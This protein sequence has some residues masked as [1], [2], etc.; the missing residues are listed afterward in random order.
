MNLSNRVRAVLTVALLFSSLFLPEVQGQAGDFFV[1]NYH[2]EEYKGSPQVFMSTEDDDGLVYF[3]SNEGV[4]IFDGSRWQQITLPNRSR[5]NHLASLDPGR[6]FVCATAEFGQLISGKGREIT[7]QSFKHRLPE[8]ERDFQEVIHCYALPDHR[9]FITR[10]RIFCIGDRDQSILAVTPIGGV[11]I[12]NDVFIIQKD[13]PGF[14]SLHP[15]GLR[16]VPKSDGLGT[17]TALAQYN[18]KEILIKTAT[19]LLRFT[20]SR[21]PQPDEP[22]SSAVGGILDRLKDPSIY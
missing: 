14:F 16:P 8:P 2:P 4:L 22:F 13:K 9:Y 15:D 21:S 7:Y 5:I 20:P 10:D 18:E 12:G 3:A 19:D 6:I 1:H 11:R 17:I